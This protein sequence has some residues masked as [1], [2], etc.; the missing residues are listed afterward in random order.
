[1]SIDLDTDSGYDE[2]LSIKEL[3]DNLPA[4]AVIVRSRRKVFNQCGVSLLR[5]TSR[6][7]TTIAY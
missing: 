2:G 7:K 3:I 5:I 4:D 6:I 1:M